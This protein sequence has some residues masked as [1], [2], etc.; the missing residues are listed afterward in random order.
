MTL[1]S[2]KEAVDLYYFGPA[3]TNGDSFVVFR[4]SRVMH[5]GDAFARKSQP[6]IDTNN[7]GSGLAYGETIGKAATGI[8]N[9]DKV[10]T[11]HGDVMAWQDLV[12]FGEFNRLF[13]AHARTSL[14]AGKT[15]EQALADFKLPPKFSG[16][17]LSPGRAGPG[18]NF[19]VIYAELRK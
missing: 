5:S 9:V 14:A 17:D 6:L 18:G 19:N 15:A 11:G 16:Y 8:K 7:G 3:H 13:L 4:D 2:G 12:D 10:I 1:F